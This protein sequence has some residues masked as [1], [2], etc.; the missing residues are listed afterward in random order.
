MSDRARTDE[1]DDVL[2]SVRKLVSHSEKNA[3]RVRSNYDTPQA[4]DRFILTPAL[5]V[6][7]HGA[8]DNPDD[9]DQIA[10]SEK[11]TD[12]VL[13][14]DRANRAD[15]AGLE[16]TIAELEAAVIAQPDDWEPDNG[17]T[18]D[19]AAWAASA[20]HLHAVEATP[21]SEDTDFENELV[22]APLPDDPAE[23][24]STPDAGALPAGIDEDAL[25]QLVVNILRDELNGDMGERI[26][27]NVRKLVRR[28]I[29]RVLVSRELD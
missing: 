23:P 3:P 28:E 25:R 10:D 5:L 18:F 19:N 24:A 2:S 29:N 16:A 11:S 20:F 26:T 6:D 1:I 22:T 13:V 14:L 27:R 12:N 15:R 7:D 8:Q 4:L 9:A 17:E 21:Q